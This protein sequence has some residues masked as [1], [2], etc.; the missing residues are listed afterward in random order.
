MRTVSFFA[1]WVAVAALLPPTTRAQDVGG[2]KP[3]DDRPYVFFSASPDENPDKEPA[4][5]LRQINLRP[6]QEQPYFV[7][8]HNPTD[9]KQT[10]QVSLVSARRIGTADQPAVAADAKIDVAA[11][12]TARVKLAANKAQL[13]PPVPAAPADKGAPVVVPAAPGIPLYGLPHFEAVSG[14]TIDKAAL[15]QLTD[16]ST[17]T[18]AAAETGTDKLK[19]VVSRKA[20]NFTPVGPPIPVRLVVRGPDGAA[21]PAGKLA[22]PEN[23]LEGSLAVDA[24]GDGSPKVELVLNTKDLGKGYAEVSID[25]VP[26]AFRATLAGEKETATFEVVAP[27]VAFPGKAL[28]VRLATDASLR[29]KAIEVAF[30]R[31]QAKGD[32]TDNAVQIKRVATHRDEGI[33]VRVGANGE[34]LFVTRARDWVFEFPTEGVFGEWEVR[35]R[36][37]A[38]DAEGKRLA[39]SEPARVVIPTPPVISEPTVAP[40]NARKGLFRPGQRIRVRADVPDPYGVIDKAAGVVF[41]LGDKPGPDGKA[42]PAGQVKV[43]TFVA[44][45]TYEAEFDLPAVV[46]PVAGAP[47]A[48]PL[49]FDRTSVVVGVIA[50]NQVGQSAFRESRVAIDPTPPVVSV[51]SVGPPKGIG[52]VY[53]PG[54]ALRVVATAFDPESDIDLTRPV[55]FFVGDPPGADG[56]PTQGTVVL[57]AAEGVIPGATSETGKPLWAADFLL[58]EDIKRDLE[59][60]VGV[61]FVNGVGTPGFR[62]ATIRVETDTT[63]GSIKATVVQG[64]KDLRQPGVVVNL[65]D[66]VG[67]IAAQAVTDECGVAKFEK[68]LP[69]RYV[70]QAVKAADAN[71]QAFTVVNVRGGEK[72]EVVLSVKR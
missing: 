40:L 62:F 23:V 45:D 52:G 36:T 70:V 28:P 13:P 68:L 16:I 31:P 53:R 47:P 34:A 9:E 8:V 59:L 57:K 12:K 42:G 65:I 24:K 19:V 17:Y 71:A 48:A 27:R 54:D 38:L 51:V 7:Y 3:P 58:P 21:L 1:A 55:L 69:G 60:R 22:A 35:A 26:R 4:N 49:V 61:W 14:K 33:D 6:N 63:V 43:G 50:T 46:L 41:Y 10:V 66:Q 64:G 30:G 5:P 18:T 37:T 11:G 39:V 25:G 44:G 29:G 2:G 72:T 20:G 15:V 67:A 56:K 32:A